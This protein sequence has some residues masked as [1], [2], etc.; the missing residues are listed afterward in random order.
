MCFMASLIAGPSIY[1]VNKQS[2]T[3]PGNA[4]ITHCRTRHHEEDTQ[5]V[6]C[7]VTSKGN[8]KSSSR[9]EVSMTMTWHNQRSSEINSR[10]F[11][12]EYLEQRQAKRPT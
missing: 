1:P 10:H 5:Y 11:E 12:E 2:K 8:Q 7:H 9:R 4:T 3:W 6:N